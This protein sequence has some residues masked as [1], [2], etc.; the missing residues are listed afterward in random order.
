MLMGLRLC[1]CKWDFSVCEEQYAHSTMIWEKC[2]QCVS[3]ASF[4]TATHT[5]T[6]VSEQVPKHTGLKGCF[7][8]WDLPY[9]NTHRADLALCSGMIFSANCL[10]CLELSSVIVRAKNLLPSFAHKPAQLSTDCQDKNS[11]RN[12][13]GWLAHVAPWWALDKIQQLSKGIRALTSAEVISILFRCSYFNPELTGNFI[14]GY[15]QQ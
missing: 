11:H 2:P 13:S 1:L 4:C 14:S 3:H 6:W 12:F 7:G 15:Q 10:K 8:K 5:Y 9:I